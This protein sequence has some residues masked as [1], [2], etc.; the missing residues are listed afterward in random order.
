MRTSEAYRQ[1]LCL[2]PCFIF[3]SLLITPCAIAR[4][5]LEPALSLLYFTNS[6]LPSI[7]HDSGKSKLFSPSA[8]LFPSPPWWFPVEWSDCGSASK[9]ANLFLTSGVKIIKEYLNTQEGE[10]RTGMGGGGCMY[11]TQSW[12][13]C[14][15]AEAVGVSTIVL[16][17]SISHRLLMT[18]C[19]AWCCVKRADH[20]ANNRFLFSLSVSY[21]LP[22]VDFLHR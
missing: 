10:A 9:D 1:S 20:W 22:S 12:F 4:F 21:H 6:P 15:K 2:L 18:L 3:A 19:I 8:F 11:C 13:R 16:D 14:V 7:D 17:Q 5:P